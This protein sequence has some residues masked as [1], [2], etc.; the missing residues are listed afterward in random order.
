M[1]EKNAALLEMDIGFKTKAC[2]ACPLSE[3]SLFH[4]PPPFSQ[5]TV[6]SQSGTR[7]TRRLPRLHVK[8]SKRKKA[9]S[10]ANLPIH[11]TRAREQVVSPNI[12]NRCTGLVI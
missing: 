3:S 12:D 7:G 2:H 11:D 10:T 9:T 8:F 6:F 5:S 1:N 4:I